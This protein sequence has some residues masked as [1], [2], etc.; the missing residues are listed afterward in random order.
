MRSTQRRERR[1]PEQ[2]DGV[3]SPELRW[4]STQALS[5]GIDGLSKSVEDEFSNAYWLCLS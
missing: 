1:P 3:S 5:H 2:N 4:R